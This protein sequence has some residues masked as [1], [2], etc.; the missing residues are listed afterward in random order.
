MMSGALAVLAAGSLAAADD[1]ERGAVNSYGQ[2]KVKSESTSP[3]GQISAK[4]ARLTT[5]QVDGKSQSNLPGG[6]IRPQKG[7]VEGAK[8]L[9]GSAAP[10]TP[11]E[12]DASQR[13]VNDLKASKKAIK[14]AATLGDPQAYGVTPDSST[15]ELQANQLKR[16]LDGQQIDPGKSYDVKGGTDSSELKRKLDSQS[17]PGQPYDTKGSSSSAELKRKLDGQSNPG[18]TYDTNTDAKAK[19]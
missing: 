14:E 8:A 4:R 13:R 19:D 3:G 5:D 11:A 10:L 9:D 17:N 15:P 2:I 7:G 6:Q 12:A 16:K 1:A 18:R